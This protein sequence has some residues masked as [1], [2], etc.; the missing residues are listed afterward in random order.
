MWVLQHVSGAKNWG[1]RTRELT[2]WN[3]PRSS[4]WCHVM[5]GD[6]TFFRTFAGSNATTNALQHGYLHRR[7]AKTN[8][9]FK[10]SERFTPTSNMKLIQ[11]HVLVDKFEISHFQS[12]FLF[13]QLVL[14]AFQNSH[15]SNSS[16][17]K[18]LKCPVPLEMQFMNNK[19][20]NLLY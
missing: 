5:V 16:P 2:F 19:K 1:Y 10:I 7:S 9:R 6:V 8:N 12:F 3:L 11:N 15:S 18:L 4:V 20:S 17:A 14:K 13:D